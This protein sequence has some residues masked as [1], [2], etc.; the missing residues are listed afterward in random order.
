MFMSLSPCDLRAVDSRAAVRGR[1]LHSPLPVLPR[2]C[3][4]V[5]ETRW[6]SLPEEE[7]SFV[8][9]PDSS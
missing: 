7:A 2:L 5:Q 1:P 4:C 6:K 3:R 8:D 9:V